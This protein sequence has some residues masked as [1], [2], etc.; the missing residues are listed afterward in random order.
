MPELPEVETFRKYLDGTALDQ[1]IVDVTLKPKSEKLARPSWAELKKKLLHQKLESSARIGKYLFIRLSDDGYLVVHFAMTGYFS[2]Y[3]DAEDEPKYAKIILHFDNG[4]HLSYNS[5][6]KFGWLDLAESIETFQ[7]EKDLGQDALEIGFEDFYQG[8]KNKKSP[9]KPRLMDQNLVAGIGNWVAD[10]MLYQAEIHPSSNCNKLS[11]EDFR[12]LYNTMQKI[13]K[14]SVELDADYDRFPEH[15][16]V[17]RREK[18]GTCYYTGEPLE[19]LEVGGRT[20]YVSK[21]R[22]KMF[23]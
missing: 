11:E 18:G 9:L 12:H 23:Q 4:F 13:L 10:E 5:K 19:V 17:N 8:L 2:Y 22:Q 20:S 3:K 1:K 15:F 14:T 6:R 21:S 7:K 16:L